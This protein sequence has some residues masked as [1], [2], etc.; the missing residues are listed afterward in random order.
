MRTS[1]FVKNFPAL[2]LS[3]KKVITGTMR[4]GDIVDLT[5][6]SLAYGGEGIARKGGLVF[7][8][9]N[10][11][12]GEQ[13]QAKIK[14]I[15]KNF[16]RAETV[17]VIQPSPDRVEPVCPYFGTC[18]GC[19]LQHLSYE[20][21]LIEKRHMVQEALEHLGR[22]RNLEVEPVVP[23]PKPFNYRNHLTFNTEEGNR[24]FG[25]G[26]VAKDNHTLI[27]VAHCS[28]A[29]TR[30]NFIIPSMRERIGKLPPNQ[31]SRLKKVIVRVGSE[32][33]AKYELVQKGVYAES[34]EAAF[35]TWVEGIP[36]YFSM[37]AF[38]QTNYFIL[39]RMNQLL[40][41]MLRPA[42]NAMLLDL[43]AGVGFF[44][45]L[46]AKSYQ[47][48]IGI[49]EG[50]QAVRDAR[51]NLETNKIDNVRILSGKVESVLRDVRSKLKPPIHVIL[52]PPRIGAA[53]PVI[54]FLCFIPIERLV[55]VSCEPSILA[56]DIR[57]L[58]RSLKVKRI[59]PLDMFPQT[60]HIETLVLMEPH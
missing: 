3:P 21:Q 15:R 30:I 32:G 29:D 54:D 5:I 16:V 36:L 49:E 59:V 22:F 39:P 38:F 28:I 53:L 48:V 7:F 33:K 19:T 1:D 52:D 31:K 51:W 47:S 12:R 10:A 43:Y 37:E 23:S 2:N 55:Y 13:V 24:A 45:V 17:K 27:D 42:G 25:F 35:V 14:S 11:L 60:K 58:S 8:V 26:F 6:H 34:R 18:G 56:R 57:Q 4:P 44:S 40:K 20:K 50:R 46:L 9:E 41:D